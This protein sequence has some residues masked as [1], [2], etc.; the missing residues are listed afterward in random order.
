MGNVG[1]RIRDRSTSDPGQPVLE[2][3][4]TVYAEKT[5][6]AEPSRGRNP[7]PL[8]PASGFIY[9]IPA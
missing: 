3:Q 2:P 5:M 1:F 8:T 7:E 9:M 4:D 6:T